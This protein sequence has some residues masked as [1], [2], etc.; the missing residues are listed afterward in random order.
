MKT[1][2]RLVKNFC[3]FLVLFIHFLDG[4]QNILK[5]S[6]N[7]SDEIKRKHPLDLDVL[8]DISVF[9]EDKS[10]SGKYVNYV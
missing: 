4:I 6:K 8:V 10:M 1:S 9:L 3:H 5:V 2:K 7:Y